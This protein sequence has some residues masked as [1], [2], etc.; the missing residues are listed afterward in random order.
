[1]KKLIAVLLITVL[2]IGI[3][4]S[5]GN[6]DNINK[7]NGNT[8]VADNETDAKTNNTNI[9]EPRIESNLPEMDFDGYNFVFLTHGGETID[10]AN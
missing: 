8:T 3:F 9:T 10:W 4:C 2:I 1:M 6:K 5:C 7:N